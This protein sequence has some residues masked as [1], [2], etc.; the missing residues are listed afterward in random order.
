[1]RSSVIAEFVGEA[2]AVEA[3]RRQFESD[4][5]VSLTTDDNLLG[6]VSQELA[7]NRKLIVTAKM[8]SDI[9]VIRAVLGRPLAVVADSMQR[10]VTMRG[11]SKLASR[12]KQYHN[13]IGMVASNATVS[14]N[15]KL[16]GFYRSLGGN[17][18]AIEEAIAHL[19][20]CCG[21]RE[22]RELAVNAD[23]CLDMIAR[24]DFSKA[25][26]RLDMPP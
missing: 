9:D 16:S 13:L 15:C 5:T 18:D 24:G 25:C 17:P 20:K 14:A 11:Q 10:G 6:R 8:S 23:D 7:D 12:V 2:L 19:S 4:W 26:T 1:M 3:R 22:L 21:N